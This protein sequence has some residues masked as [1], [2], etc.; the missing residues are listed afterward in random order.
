MG[1][2]CSTHGYMRNAY[3]LIGKPETNKPAGRSRRRLMD[4]IKLDL[5][6]LR[7]RGSEVDSCCIGYSP[8]AGFCENGDETSS[9]L[10]QETI[11]FSKSRGT[12][13][14]SIRTSHHQFT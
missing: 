3:N 6:E 2:T 5:R 7:V 10:P 4:N 14:F 8:V 13:N 12:V 1:G 9:S 11:N